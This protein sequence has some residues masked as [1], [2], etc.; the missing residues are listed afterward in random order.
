MERQEGGVYCLRRKVLGVGL[1]FPEWL[2]AGWSRQGR[3]G[4]IACQWPSRKLQLQLAIQRLPADSSYS[5]KPQM[6]VLLH[7]FN[8]LLTA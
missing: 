1:S 4:T 6:I 8:W 3:R 2:F 7:R 5:A